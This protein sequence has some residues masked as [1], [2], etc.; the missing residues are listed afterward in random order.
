MRPLHLIV[1]TTLV[2]AA[3]VA[4]A[5]DLYSVDR[6]TNLLRQVNPA[7]G[8]TINT[9]AM[10][11]G[12]TGAN[13]L[14]AHPNT[15]DL[16]ALLK[17]PGGA[18]RALGT[19][20]PN[21][22]NVD[23]VG[24]TGDSFAGIAFDNGGTLY[25]VTGDGAD[26]PSSLF[27]L[28]LTDASPTFFMGLGN[29]FDGEA[30]GYNNDSGMM[31]HASGIDTDEKVWEEID[32]SIPAIINSTILDTDPPEE[33]LAFTYKGGGEFYMVDRV[34]GPGGDSGF[35]TIDTA[36]NSVLLGGMDYTAKGLAF[37]PIPTPATGAL[38]A[39]AGIAATR[40]RR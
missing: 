19:V 27:T 16:W 35:F 8:S 9:I 39:L 7:D 38:L 24:F 22:G 29:G 28:S 33:I 12:V 17:I 1:C 4:S 6:D 40:R 21:T 32:L 13:G 10:D 26:T 23:V 31:F 30:I 20:D 5:Q 34:S 18:G 3:G 37:Y 25:G 15:G 2:A 14:A 11:G 36:G